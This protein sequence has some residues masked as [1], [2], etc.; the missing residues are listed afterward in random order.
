MPV[1]GR[2]ADDQDSGHEQHEV[3]RVGQQAAVPGCPALRRDDRGLLRHR[4]R[5]KHRAHR[6]AL[7]AAGGRHRRRACRTAACGSGGTAGTPWDRG[8]AGRCRAKRRAGRMRPP[9]A[10]GPRRSGR[11]LGSTSAR[12]G[13]PAIGLGAGAAGSA[14]PS[15]FP[16]GRPG[17][18]W[19]VGAGGLRAGGGRGSR[20]GRRAS[21]ARRGPRARRL[22]LPQCLALAGPSESSGFAPGVGSA[23]HPPAAWA[24]AWALAAAGTAAGAP[25]R[26]AA[27]LGGLGLGGRRPLP[28]PLP[29]PPPARL[30]S[31]RAEAA[32]PAA[33]PARASPAAAAPERGR[34]PPSVRRRVPRR[35]RGHGPPTR[36]GA[37]RLAPA[38]SRGLRERR[39]RATA[40]SPA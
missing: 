28:R 22:R 18:R 2:A 19:R 39:A 37:S 3:A 14:G 15:G 1:H 38:R 5:R 20:A 21:S 26:V 25:R 33:R 10:A 7:P 12:P 36:A 8:R 13:H 9:V 32:D 35:A 29:Q 11:F 30:A 40:A 31:R 27:C 4:T 34:A 23:A 24:A 16:P 6:R 17:R